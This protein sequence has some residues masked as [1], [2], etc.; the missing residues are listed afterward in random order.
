VTVTLDTA[1]R[2]F[3]STSEDRDAN[4]HSRHGDRDHGYREQQHKHRESSGYGWE[5]LSRSIVATSFVST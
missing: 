1:A 4:G 5:R 3:E 2:P